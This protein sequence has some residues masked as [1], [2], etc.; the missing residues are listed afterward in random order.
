M[1]SVIRGLLYDCGYKVDS[2][3]S[4]DSPSAGL[5]NVSDFGLFQERASSAGRAG[6]RSRGMMNK[7]A[8]VER[9]TRSGSSR[10]VS[11][12]NVQGFGVTYFLS[13]YS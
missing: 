5:S 7:V 8:D 13:L 11:V 3:S 6:K 4:S 2:S 1:A 10:L 12:L 9:S